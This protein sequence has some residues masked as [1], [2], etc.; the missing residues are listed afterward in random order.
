MTRL[1]HIVCGLFCF[2]SLALAGE[3]PLPRV[4]EN[5]D[6]AQSFWDRHVHYPFPHRY[7]KVADTQGRLWELAYVDLFEGDAAAREK[8]PVLVMLHGRAMN[9]G[10]WGL[11]LEKPLAAG[12]RVISIDWSH[13]GKSLPR[14]LDL[15]VNRN[16]DDARQALFN[17]VVK[18]LGIARATY[19]GHSM[20]GQIAAGYAIA[21]PENVERL[22][23]YAPGGLESFPAI[24]RHGVRLDD[25]ALARGSDAFLAEWE[26]SGLLPSMGRTREAVE[27]SFYDDQRP[28]SLP[29]LQRGSA[30][31]EF[32]VASRAAILRGNPRERERAA[33]SYGWD[34]LA[35]LMEC[36]VEDADAFPGRLARLKV[37]TLLALGVKD[38]VYPIPGSGNT[39]LVKDTVQVVYLLVGGR[40]S[41]VRIK[42]YPEGGHFLHIDLPEQF[43][44][45]VL[46]FITAG[47]VAEPL[48]AGD[49]ERYL[50]PPRT[51]LA[52]LPAEVEGFR[53]RFEQ[54][55]L[56]H[57]L[58]AVE[59]LFHPDYR[60]NG[61]GRAQRLKTYE[62]F[63][64]MV[65][66][67]EL[68]IYAIEREGD[69]LVLDAETLTDL[70]AFPDK[71]RLKKWEGEWRNYGNQQ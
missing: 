33:L 45:E 30:F 16:F 71:I 64:G 4:D 56:R 42:L 7:A 40:Q 5:I 6:P 36:R 31:N 17:L 21:H 58:Q 62:S 35:A 12:W 67:W 25:P 41:P 19:L 48:Y 51:P 69:L 50:P 24:Y 60:K 68:K 8:A 61:E 57:D 65:T 38:P 63:I 39:S 43:S 70:G 15:P 49:P 66:R 22:V 14:N 26:K 32:I 46:D 54:A 3:L 13:T 55:F 53:Q 10:Y 28:G 27:R 1:I 52:D 37:P 11:L 23:L 44:R 9:S 34:T 29:Y 59:A 20:G 18:H 47:K 2:F